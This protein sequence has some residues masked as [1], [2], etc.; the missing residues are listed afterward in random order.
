[1]DQLSGYLPRGRRSSLFR[2]FQNLKKLGNTFSYFLFFTTFWLF[3]FISNAQIQIIPLTQPTGG[4]HIDGNLR[5]N[6]P[7]TGIGDWI[8]GAVGI[9][10]NLYRLTG[11]P[12]NGV[13]SFRV[14]DPYAGG[15]GT[16]RGFDGGNKFNDN[17]NTWGWTA[18]N[19][20]PGKN[21]IN[22]IFYHLGKSTTT[23]FEGDWILISGDRKEVQGT[24]YIDFE[25]LQN[26]LIRTGTGSSG[27]FSSSGPDGGRTVND[28]LIAVE[29]T[30]GG[31]SATI[32]AYR[33]EAV[34]G[35]FDYV[36]KGI[37]NSTAYPLGTAYGTTNSSSIAVPYGA[38]GSTT[39]EPQQW[40]EVGVNLTKLLGQIDPCLGIIV[41][42]IFVKTK[43]SDSN[44][45]DIKDFIDPIP[46]NLAFGTATISYDQ[47]PYCAGSGTAAVNRN[48]VD[49]GKYTYTA[50]TQGS[51]L[52][53]DQNTGEINLATSTPGTYTVEYKF[54]SFPPDFQDPTNPKT[55]EKTVET[56]VVINPRPTVTTPNTATVCS[57]ASPNISLTASIP[58]TFT[59]T[60]GNIAGGITGASAG[61]GATINQTLTNPSNT[62][63]GT[64]QYIVTPTSTTGSC[65]GAPYTITVTVNPRPTI[66]TPNITTV[67]SGASPNISLTASTPSTFTWTV[68][69]ITGGITGA[70]AGSGATINQILTNP[71]NTTAGTVQYIVTPTSTTGSCIGAQYTI[72]V[73]VNPSTSI[74]S[75]PTGAT[76][77]Q[78]S[79]ATP[80]TVTGT[81]TGT[82]TYEW[83]Q[84][85]SAENTGGTRV[86]TTQNYTPPTNTEGTF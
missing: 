65:A 80:L 3:S 52:I 8:P 62:T 85:T 39:Y 26:S 30:K 40:V 64:V 84:T 57:G 32:K 54:D 44:T 71:S 27:G 19:V 5:A 67:C 69:N 75:Q 38:F 15:P 66:T 42:S 81:G 60:I 68:G 23:G 35:S 4:F 16:D 58:S 77:C 36:F 72:T 11:A 78:N 47:S 31:S 24:S 34:S 53:I 25:F 79:T 13:T 51:V 43:A 55:C 1:M 17:P 28:L 70:S 12:I 45:A 76:Y 22:N 33:W 37:V 63:A 49:G 20:N 7:L 61:S 6:D 9:G 46:V 50:Q 56:T 14:E 41:K 83:W 48:G 2:D 18:G 86:A 82:I 21:D 73:T 10:G 74:T 29:Y 59:W